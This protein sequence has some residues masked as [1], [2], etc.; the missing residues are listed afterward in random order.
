MVLPVVTLAV[1]LVARRRFDQVADRHMAGRLTAI[2]AA[3]LGASCGVFLLLGSLLRDQIG[4]RSRVGGVLP[5][6]SALF[7]PSR[8]FGSRLPPQD[9]AGRLLFSVG[10][11][12][13]LDGRP[14]CAHRVLPAHLRLP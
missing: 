14:R 2:V 11:P 13:V 7:L 3:A 5:E 12:A 8:L 9:V 6:L 4:A 1:L 10:L